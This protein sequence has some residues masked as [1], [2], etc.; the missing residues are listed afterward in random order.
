MEELFSPSPDTTPKLSLAVNV[1]AHAMVSHSAGGVAQASLD[2]DKDWEE[3]FQTP[4]SPVLHMVRREEGEQGEPAAEQ[5]EAS[6]GSL[7]W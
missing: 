1:L 6:G 7:A 4:H 2:D 3:D 5:M